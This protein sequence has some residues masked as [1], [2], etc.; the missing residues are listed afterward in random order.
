MQLYKGM[1]IGTAKIT[2]DERKGITHHMMDLLDVSQD[3]N[4]AWYQEKARAVISEIHGRK[5]DAIIAELSLEPWLDKPVPE[6]T[7]D[8][9]KSRMSHEKFE[10]VFL[11]QSMTQKN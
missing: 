3:A 8:I 5:R 7:L 1:D 4:V 11:P 10:K 2:M 6:E 9:Q